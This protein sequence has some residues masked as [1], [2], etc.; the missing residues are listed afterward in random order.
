MYILDHKPALAMAIG[1]VTT[2]AVHAA[3]VPMPPDNVHVAVSLIT[4]VDEWVRLI[5]GIAGALAGFA[6]ATWYLYSF[7]SARRKKQ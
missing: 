4:V 5:G 3:A 6:S 7:I 2:A 1:S